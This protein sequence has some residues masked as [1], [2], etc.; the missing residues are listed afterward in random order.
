M[1]AQAMLLTPR[2]VGA[3]AVIALTGPDAKRA[4]ETLTGPITIQSGRM[5][6]AVF[7]VQ[8]APLDDGLVVCVGDDHFE[9]HLHGS[10]AIVESVL[11][12]LAAAGVTVQAAGAPAGSAL[13]VRLTTAPWNTG[14]HAQILQALPQ[15]QSETALRLLAAQADSGLG[16]WARRW[17]ARLDDGA[18]L[19]QFHAAA[20]WVLDRSCSLDRLLKPAR[21]V[22]VGAPNAGKSTL[23]NALLGR[24]VSVTSALAGTTRDWVDATALLRV[25]D[26]S[27]RPGAEA[28]PLELPITWVDTAGLRPSTDPLEQVA[29]E[30]T[31]AQ[32][33]TADV[34][35]VVLDATVPP[36]RALGP[37][38]ERIEAVSCGGAAR[39]V[40]I[41]ANKIDAATPPPGLVPPEWGG[42]IL[43]V[44]AL[45]QTGLAELLDDVV[46][47][48]GLG[49]LAGN[50]A[51]AEPWAFTPT[52]R[53]DLRTLAESA[54]VAQALAALRRCDP[55]AIPSSLKTSL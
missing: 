37:W 25:G 15:A 32:L 3:I 40:R 13:A 50:F 42:R 4:L 5:R 44:S 45:R 1:N 31:I 27:A 9:I 2:A 23:V 43:G 20:Q 30:R 47:A 10:L 19:W 29:M 6:R 22:L 14:L 28:A 34:V 55:P 36:E 52:L 33:R 53:E 35:F 11:A 26:P 17:Q 21:V 46:A 54:S 24:A 49:G 48:L 18:C 12:A 7:V 51:P 16:A 8:G 41:V 38:L 39:K